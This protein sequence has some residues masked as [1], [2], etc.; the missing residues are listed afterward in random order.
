MIVRISYMCMDMHRYTFQKFT[1]GYMIQLVYEIENMKLFMVFKL[2]P[3]FI[4]L[5]WKILV[6]ALPVKSKL[7][8]FLFKNYIV[9]FAGRNLR[10]NDIYYFLKHNGC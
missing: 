8:H 6:G 1:R 3:K 7:T 4:M 2:H 10:L 5:L 9:V